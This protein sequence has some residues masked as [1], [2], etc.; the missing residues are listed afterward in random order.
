MES[1]AL[2]NEE[3]TVDSMERRFGP[4]LYGTALW[5]CLGYRSIHSFRQA[6]RLGTVPVEI[7]SIPS[8]KG[9]FARTKDVA[10]WLDSLSG[11]NFT[12]KREETMPSN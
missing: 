10:K 4:L 2:T 7:F 6:I 8:R 9:R 1:I 3:T 11:A 12:G 5:Q